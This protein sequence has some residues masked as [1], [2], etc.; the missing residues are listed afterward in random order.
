MKIETT[1]NEGKLSVVLE[2]RLDSVTADELSKVLEEK[3]NDSTASLS[4]DLK[5]VDFVSSKGLRVLVSAYRQLKGK[6]LAL[7]NPNAS[8]KDVLRLSGLLKIF[9]IIEE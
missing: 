3:L 8:V 1:E 6:E 9:R 7:V 5:N 2:G 4:V